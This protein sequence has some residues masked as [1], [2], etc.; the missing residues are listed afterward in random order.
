M[1]YV[2]RLGRCLCKCSVYTTRDQQCF[3]CSSLRAGEVRHHLPFAPWTP[4]VL[5]DVLMSARPVPQAPPSREAVSPVGG[6]AGWREGSVLLALV[7]LLPTSKLKAH[8]AVPASL[9]H[10][11]EPPLLGSGLGFS[12]TP[13]H[14]NTHVCAP[15]VTQRREEGSLWL[16]A[17]LKLVAVI[18]VCPVQGWRGGVKAP[19]DL[20][21]R[22]PSSPPPH[23]LLCFP[24]G[25]VCALPRA[26]CRL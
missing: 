15:A 5:V 1:K 24:T 23:C 7:S 10:Q 19:P 13:D 21:G 8:A 3:P 17:S 20:L 26:S 22:H 11:G 4:V 16:V 14:P 18:I 12:F 6:G 9:H 25:S 2:K